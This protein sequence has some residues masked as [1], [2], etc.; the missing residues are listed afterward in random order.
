VSEEPRSIAI[1]GGWGYIGQKFIEAACRLGLR[2]FVHDPAPVPDS[3]A[4]LP[5]DVVEDEARFYA[6]PVD[7]YHLALHPSHRMFALE[8]LFERGET[9]VAPVILCEKPL[10]DPANPGDGQWLLER[11]QK[12]GVI[13]LI[14][15]IELFDDLTLKVQRFLSEFSHVT[16]TSVHMWRSKDREDPANPRNYKII[17]PIQYQETVHCIAYVLSLF[18]QLP[19]GLEGALGNGV[20]VSGKSQLYC[21]PNPLDYPV[22]MDGKL[23]ADVF[24]GETAVRFQTNFKSGA[25]LTKRRVIEGIGDGKPFR[26]EAEHL[27][28]RKY[29]I[30]DGVREEFPPDA[31]AYQQVIQRSIRWA[32]RRDGMELTTDLRYPNAPFAWYTYLLSAMLWDSCAEGTDKSIHTARELWQY[33]PSYPQHHARHMA[34]QT[35]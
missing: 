20:R 30:V 1:A 33:T 27:E 17:V 18:A 15:F 35:G 10:A 26:I 34:G 14:D 8:R 25:T 22:P 6:L 32:R 9:G 24:I 19:G 31:D 16:L 13:V 12:T 5:I 2:V 29:L 7:L 23:D 11:S 21:P 28:G 4:G 3:I